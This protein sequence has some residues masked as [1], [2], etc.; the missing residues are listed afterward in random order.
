[1]RALRRTEPEVY[2]RLRFR[3]GEEA[4]I[5][6]GTIGRLAVD[7]KM[8]TVHLFVMTLCFSRYA[9]YELVTDQRVPTFLGA[10]RRAFEYFG[11]VPERIK[12]DSLRSAV[13]VDALGQRYYQEDFFRLCRHYGT[14]ADAA[15]PATPTDKGRTERD[16]GYAKGNC[17]RGR[18]F[19]G[20]EP[21]V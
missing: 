14:V 11:G 6:F 21:A 9:Y 19:A 15:R 4:Q 18:A 13:L 7:G 1:M 20:L 17:F 3:P 12:P 16:I 2:C 8:R 10:I 5:D